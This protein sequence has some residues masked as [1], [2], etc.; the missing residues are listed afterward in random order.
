M[1]SK[2]LKIT[3]TLQDQILNRLL[4]V[5]DEGILHSKSR[6]PGMPK[7]NKFYRQFKKLDREQ[8]FYKIF[9]NFRIKNGEPTGL[10][11]TYLGNELLKRNFDYYEFSHD[12][13]PTPK[14]YVKLDRGMEWP[15][16]F[17]KKKLT[18]YS[19]EDASWFKLNGSEIGAFIEII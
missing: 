15:Y 5:I 3:N 12:V 6:R 9:D 7:N 4:Q 1:K 11:L 8:L 2:P 16:Y 17:T 10:R 14:M 18:L 19:K 13:T